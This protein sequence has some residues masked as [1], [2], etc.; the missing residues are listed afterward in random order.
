MF[1]KLKYLTLAKPIHKIPY[2]IE[3]IYWEEQKIQTM[4]K[5]LNFE[6]KSTKLQ[7]LKYLQ[8]C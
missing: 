6:K 4:E 7:K 5:R 1:S 8:K 2:F 3:N